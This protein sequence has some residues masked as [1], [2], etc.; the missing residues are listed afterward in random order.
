MQKLVAP[1][2]VVPSYTIYVMYGSNADI[3]NVERE[4]RGEREKEHM[5][6]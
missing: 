2:C 1:P 5:Q 3:F 4:K 6:T